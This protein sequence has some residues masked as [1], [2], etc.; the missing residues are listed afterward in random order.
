VSGYTGP[1]WRDVV[2]RVRRVKS[3]ENW[4]EQ[5]THGEQDLIDEYGV[6]YWCVSGSLIPG[7]FTWDEARTPSF[8]LSSKPG[9]ALTEARD[10]FKALQDQYQRALEWLERNG[11]DPPRLSWKDHAGRRQPGETLTQWQERTLDR[12]EECLSREF[13][14]QAG[15][16]EVQERNFA[17]PRTVVPAMQAAPPA[18]CERRGRT[19]KYDREDAVA[20][21]EQTLKKRGPFRPKWDTESGWTCQA[22]LERE[23][24]DYMEK[25]YGRAPA[26]STIR[27]YVTEFL[28]TDKGR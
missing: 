5:P 4:I 23:L 18:R 10:R 20:F 13:S 3:G 16:F 14:P 2:E 7:R 24:A 11:V 25:H 17:L 27:S 21:M 12:L 26:E 19:P 6:G 28:E 1:T 15:P 9:L 22:D 8:S